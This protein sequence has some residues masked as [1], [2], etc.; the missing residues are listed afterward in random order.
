MKK[1]LVPCDF[2]KPA[3]NAF[4]FA[5]DIAQQSNGS[6]HL[7]NSIDLT[8]IQDPMMMPALTLEQGFIGELKEKASEELTKIITKYNQEDVKVTWSIEF[9][10]PARVITEFVEKNSIDLIIMGSHGA[11]GFSEYFV[12]SNAER[13][14]RHS[15][16][17]VLVM[18]H[19]YKGP[20]K[21]IV[22][23]NILDTENQEDLIT[24]V[25]A[26]QAFFKATVHILFVNT[27]IN[28]TS[29]IVTLARLKEFVKR[30]MFKN[31]T[32][33]IHNH[34]YEDEGIISFTKSIKG[35]LI[36]MG[37]HGRKGI[38]H[39]LKG[40]LAEDVANHTDSLIWTYTLK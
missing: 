14:I 23:P 20:I 25:K 26:L 1:I 8:G 13:I 35:N 2:S 18:K 33:N 4:R 7:L 29:D 17:P 3:I 28:F 19:Y 39:L 11:S 36:A 24:K 9:G 32:I 16:V 27:P 21:S 10:S 31:Y 15:S 6:V 40:S 5:L 34:I 38:S 30:N 12:G 22:F 37:T